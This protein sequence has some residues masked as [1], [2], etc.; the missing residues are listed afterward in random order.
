MPQCKGWGDTCF[1]SGSSFVCLFVLLRLPG[2]LI[3]LSWKLVWMG[4]EV[5]YFSF[6]IEACLP[7]CVL[8]THRQIITALGPFSAK[9]IVLTL[10]DS[11]CAV[12]STAVT[13]ESG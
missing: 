1:V 7:M 4:V 6:Q 3:I 10:N 12:N 5:L 13:P 9:R 11:C 8:L 2:F